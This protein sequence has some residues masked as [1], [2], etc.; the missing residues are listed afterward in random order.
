M[1]FNI[2]QQDWEDI[3]VSIIEA[4]SKEEAKQI[5]LEQNSITE[6]AEL[7]YASRADRFY[8]HECEKHFDYPHMVVESR[9]EYWGMPCS[10]TVG[11]CPLCGGWDFEEVDV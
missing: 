3:M 4:D 11:Y 5:Y 8:C 10:E 2:Y 9:G 7:F 1:R 6:D